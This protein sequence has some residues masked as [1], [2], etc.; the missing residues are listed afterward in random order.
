MTNFA[1]RVDASMNIGTGHVIRCLT[2]A[3]AL[4]AQ[5]AQCQFICRAHPGHLMDIIRSRGYA[6]SCLAAPV[7]DD[8]SHDISTAWLGS[9]WKDDALETEAALDCFSLDWLVV[10][11]YAID[12]RWEATLKPRYKKLMVIDDLADRPH[13]CDLLLDQNWFSEATLTRYE[14]LVPTHC[15]CFFGPKFA[16]LKHEYVQQRAAMSP[17]DGNI[18]RVLVF[19]GGSD[20]TN[21]TAKV[22]HALSVPDLRSLAVDVVIGKNHPDRLGIQM[23]VE[24]RHS[25]VLHQNLPHLA[26]LM[27]QADL[28]VGAGGATAWER[29]CLGLPCI[30]ISTAAN[31]TVC[32]TA[33]MKAGYIDF[34][35]EM[36]QITV[37]HIS[38]ALKRCLT[39]PKNIRNQSIRGQ[40]LVS[41]TGVDEIMHSL[42]GYKLTQHET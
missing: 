16:L 37:D 3:D 15:Q 36:N 20:P 33:L 14:N 26:G 41:G 39:N 34:L 32:S 42:L 10:D 22:L 5:G 25:T 24:A 18:R 40:E 17:R 31:Q 11:H 13:C 35:G 12:Q 7:L 23:L 21:Q 19:M 38:A 6:V 8:Q 30:V 1:F 27:A 28:M 2:L 29:M 9:T 4:R